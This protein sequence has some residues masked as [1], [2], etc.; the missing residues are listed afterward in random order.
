MAGIEVNKNDLKNTINTT[1][2]TYE[3]LQKDKNSLIEDINDLKEDV[4]KRAKQY[5]DNI[6]LNAIY[7][8][9]LEA[10]K[11]IK[12][13]GV[14]T[15]DTSKKLSSSTTTSKSSPAVSSSN[16]VYDDNTIL[17]IG[18]GED[19]GM[20]AK[21]AALQMDN[22]EKEHPNVYMTV[23]DEINS[24]SDDQLK[25]PY[26][27]IYR[28]TINKITESTTS[29]TESTTSTI[30]S[31]TTST[32]SSKSINRINFVGYGG[33]TGAASAM[34]TKKLEIYEA[35][36]PDHKVSIT[37]I[38]ND[39]SDNPKYA[40][41]V[42]Y[43]CEVEIPSTSANDTTDTTD[44]TTVDQNSIKTETPKAEAKTEENVNE[45]LKYDE[46][47]SPAVKF[48]Q[49]YEY[50][51]SN[52]L[53]PSQ[54]K[55]MNSCEIDV[56]SNFLKG[57]SIT[58]WFDAIQQEGVNTAKI[59]TKDGNQIYLKDI[60]KLNELYD[61]TGIKN[62]KEIKNMLKAMSNTDELI[63]TVNEAAN[64]AQLG[65]VSKV[66]AG[67]YGLDNGRIEQGKTAINNTL[68]E[69]KKIAL[70][71]ITEFVFHNIQHMIGTFEDLCKQLIGEMPTKIAG[72]TL[73]KYTADLNINGLNKIIE[74]LKKSE[75]ENLEK[76]IQNELN[77][78][79]QAK[80]GEIVGSFNKKMED[81]SKF[82]TD[83]IKS[84]NAIIDEIPEGTKWIDTQVNKQ[85][86]NVYA[87]IGEQLFNSYEY[88]K[89]K[90]DE[91][92]KYVGDKIGE[93]NAK[94]ANKKIE[95]DAIKTLQQAN[96]IKTMA[97]SFAESQKHILKMW[98]SRLLKL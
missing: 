10:Q 23:S 8:E 9:Y 60:V 67:Y 56:T 87:F 46:V 63:N 45:E 65:G 66:I 17:F 52:R 34:A 73:E 12:N 48:L 71:S 84:I 97:S 5:G 76:S 92:A 53:T 55:A 20:S 15:L 27:T 25:G 7:K 79:G 6:D 77:K 81:I 78:L 35:E 11:T 82:A 13:G 72:F 28:C 96:K 49:F 19:I 50:N 3:Q 80:I 2:K 64:I 58:S 4:I 29:T 89:Q 47:T 68:N 93:F 54:L 14:L 32:T 41:M 98:L 22:Y 1:I 95:E 21:M 75:Q 37:E 36:H 85:M 24:R 31:S 69:M 70:S 30:K 88:I 91:A 90:R 33:D 94:K 74:D 44:N 26:M 51:I 38:K 18:Y 57:N 42:T 43:I 16:S 39:Y 59:F 86:E 83:G 40:Y 62:F 61:F